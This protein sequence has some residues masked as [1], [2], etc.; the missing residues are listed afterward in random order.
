MPAQHAGIC[1]KYNFRS[2]Q[3]KSLKAITDGFVS[4]LMTHLREEISTLL[5]LDDYDGTKL[6]KLWLKIEE[7]PKGAKHPNQLVSHIARSEFEVA[8]LLASGD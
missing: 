6:M 8:S 1:H 4:A 2:I 5:G 3:L 7:F